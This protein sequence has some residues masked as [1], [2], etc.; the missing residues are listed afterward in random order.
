MINM[1]IKVNLLEQNPKYNI[2]YIPIR[3]G[4]IKFEF[5]SIFVKN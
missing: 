1:N 2:V 4:G 3:F 5:S